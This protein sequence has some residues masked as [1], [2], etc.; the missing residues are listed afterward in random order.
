MAK[1][2][3]AA[4]RGTIKTV[5]KGKRKGDLITRGGKRYRVVSYKTKTGKLVR[6][7]Q[8]VSKCGSPA[9]KASCK[10]RVT[11]KKRKTKARKNPFLPAPASLCKL[12]KNRSLW[13]P[14]HT[15]IDGR[16]TACVIQRT[17][18]KGK[19]KFAAYA[20]ST[21]VRP[22]VKSRPVGKTFTFGG[23][24]FKVVTRKTKAGGRR[25]AAVRL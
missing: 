2:N 21:I 16:G 12:P 5:P 1:S 11:A 10:V 18:A 4:I 23:K 25:K 7:L 19:P 20:H 14:G 15:Y 13:Y 17:R 24:R 8:A 22:S 9:R 6:Y 3:P